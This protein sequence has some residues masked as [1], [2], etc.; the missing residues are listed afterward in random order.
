MDQ[1][2][3]EAASQAEELLSAAR[4][5]AES[6]LAAAR[7]EAQRQSGEI[8]SQAQRQADA[9]RGQ[10]EG[11]MRKFCPNALEKVNPWRASRALIA[12]M[13]VKLSI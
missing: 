13:S 1:I 8:L 3:Q 6:T 5:E 7:E 9:I 12:P 4:T 10:T 11:L 2:Q